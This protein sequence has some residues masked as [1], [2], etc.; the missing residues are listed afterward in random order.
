MSKEDPP[1]WTNLIRLYKTDT[2]KYI[3][4]NKKSLTANLLVGIICS[5]LSIC[6][7]VLSVP[8]DIFIYYFISVIFV[9]SSIDNDNKKASLYRPQYLSVEMGA[10][11]ISLIAGLSIISVYSGLI[12]FT[13]ALTSFLLTSGS[14]VTIIP[15]YCLLVSLFSVGVIDGFKNLT[16]NKK[17]NFSVEDNSDN[18]ENLDEEKEKEIA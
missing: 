12:G 13:D 3:R 7:S 16:N 15:L 18:M 14:I 11:L 10:V 2:I 4:N 17:S 5:V 9:A 1:S 6:I 8:G